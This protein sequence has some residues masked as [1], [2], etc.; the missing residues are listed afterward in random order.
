MTKFML[1]FTKL[2]I[3]FRGDNDGSI[4][5]AIFTNCPGTDGHLFHMGGDSSWFSYGFHNKRS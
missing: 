1:Q 2:L 5:R 3:S 4:F